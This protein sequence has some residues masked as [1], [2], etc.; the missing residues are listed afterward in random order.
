MKMDEEK[1]ILW[2]MVP[3][4]NFKIYTEDSDGNEILIA[5]SIEGALEILR[6]NGYRVEREFKE[7]KKD[8]KMWI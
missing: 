1:D 8:L 7:W 5:E 3:V 6:H 2:E 4:R